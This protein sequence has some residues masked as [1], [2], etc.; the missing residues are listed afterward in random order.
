MLIRRLI[1]YAFLA[2]EGDDVPSA[3]CVGVGGE[4]LNGAPHNTPKARG[5]PR[6][7]R[8]NGVVEVPTDGE[9]PDL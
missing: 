4:E 2:V 3:R 7:R 1:Y 8:E 6:K 9:G 5:P